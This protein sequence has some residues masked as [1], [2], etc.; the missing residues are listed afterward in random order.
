[1]PP[2]Q[3][4]RPVQPLGFCTSLGFWVQPSQR[5]STVALG[6]SKGFDQGR[7]RVGMDFMSRAAKLLNP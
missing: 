6:P 1:M 7:R 5:A 2:I 4:Y 3:R